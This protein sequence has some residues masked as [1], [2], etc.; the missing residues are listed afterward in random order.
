[1]IKK[2]F[3]DESGTGVLYEVDPV[4]EPEE[5][6]N[7]HRQVKGETVPA[8]A[9]LGKKGLMAVLKNG[10]RLYAAGPKAPIGRAP[11]QLYMIAKPPCLEKDHTKCGCGCSG[12]W[13][14]SVLS[15]KEAAVWCKLNGVPTARLHYGQE[16][17][18]AEVSITV[19]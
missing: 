6:V 3:I 5:T 2:T 17:K 1:M 9:K 7:A 8:L 15:A 11:E 12:H 16:I 18:E 4:T 14:V 10:H 19:R 13:A